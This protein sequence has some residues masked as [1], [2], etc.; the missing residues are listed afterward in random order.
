MPEKQDLNDALC[1]V[2]GNTCRIARTARSYEWNVTGRHA[3]TAEASFQDQADE[4]MAA[5]LDIARHVRGLGTIAIL[6]YS[7]AVVEVN[8]PTHAA[9]P[10]LEKM[11][12]NLASGHLQ[13]NHSIGAAMDI[14]RELDEVPTFVFLAARIDVHRRHRHRVELVLGGF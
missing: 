11:C 6:D 2:L 3:L 4:L 12:Q 5:T 14:A 7:D 10:T 1:H 13:A 8:P 9:M